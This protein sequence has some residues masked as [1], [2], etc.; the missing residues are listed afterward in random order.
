[1]IDSFHIQLW[2]WN[3][4]K[5]LL[6]ANKG[7]SALS[8][9]T[10]ADNF[11]CYTDGRSVKNSISISAKHN[12]M[13][14][15]SYYILLLATTSL[16]AGK[17]PASFDWR[18]RGAVGPVRNQGAI[19]NAAAFETVASIESLKFIQSGSLVRLSIPEV[20]D[21]CPQPIDTL[22][23]IVRKLHGL[24]SEAGYPM[25]TGTCHSSSCTPIVSVSGSVSIKSG[26]ET[27]LQMAVLQ[28]PVIAL[29]DASHTSFQIYRGGIYAEPKCSQTKLDHA[30][31]VV[32]YGS[33]NGNDYWICQNS[34]G[35][36]WG[37]HGYVWIARNKSNMC[38][39]AT[40]ASYPAL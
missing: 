8:H 27:A 1:M 19:G 23:C 20:N 36:G 3:Y 6:Q 25:S 16:A 37:M 31:L 38:G 39:I 32:G 10:Q 24:C 4:D 14:I 34:W 7:P 21:C 13:A 2:T 18:T 17:L 29:I 28:N 5:T 30:V 15:A 33:M 9:Q 40:E 35:A 11:H 26:N 12:N 22:G